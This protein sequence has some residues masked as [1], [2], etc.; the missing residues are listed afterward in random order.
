[1]ARNRLYVLLL[2]IPFLELFPQNYSFAPHAFGP[3]VAAGGIDQPRFQF[4]DIDGDGDQ[5]LF[6]LDKDELLWFYRNV[7]GQLRLEPK[8]DFSLT[9]G[10]WFRF[11]DIDHDGDKDCFTNGQFSE[12]AL[13]KNT[14]SPTVPRFQ[15]FSAALND[16]S[17]LELFS[18]RFS[19]PAFAD[20]DADGDDDLFSGGSIGSIAFYKN[21]GTP[22]IPQ[23]T[24]VTSAFNG[25]NIQGGG[26]SFPKVMHGASGIEFFD[27][28]SNGVLDLF[29]GDYFNP[30]LYYLQNTG[31]KQNAN[32]VLVDSTYPNEAVVQSY[33]FNVPQHVDV[34]GD[35]AVD[36]MIGSVFP[37]TEYD[38]MQFYKNTGTNA[39]P[40]YALQSKNF[41]PMI[42]AG[43]RSSVAAADFDGD[44]DADL[45]ITSAL[46]TVQIFDNTGTVSNPVFHVQPQSTFSLANNFYATVTAGDINNDGKIDLLIGNYDGRIR[47]FANT[48]SDGVISF[49]HILYPLDQ[50]DAGQNSAPCIVDIDHNGTNDVLVG[51]SGGHVV[52]L[53]NTGTNAAPVYTADPGFS[54]FDVGNDAIPF[55]AD[56]DKDGILDLLI[57]NNEGRMFQYKQ[58]SMS[59]STFD[60]VTEK[61]QNIDL[62]TQLS[63]CVFDMDHD[64]DNDLILGNGKGGIYYYERTA[65]ASRP[66]DNGALPSTVEV[67]QNY[68]NPFNPSTT[69]SFS[70]PQEARVTIEIIDVLGRPVETLTNGN[71]NAGKHS[72]VWNASHVAT[73]PYFYHVVVNI[74]DKRVLFSGKILYIK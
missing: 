54:P 7:N 34:D 43:S 12:V 44:G 5:D 35:G 67:Y 36:L 26:G 58:S 49:S 45:V 56:V 70:L 51:E 8:A 20:I 23:F 61:F 37:T 68:P 40:Y 2:C 42:D 32:L 21:I 25:I 24:F 19:I 63:P 17:G 64:G 38:N 66:A 72:I 69:I 30:S 3:N 60:L 74:K 1:M 57:G 16:T 27:A 29:W 52:L 73:G 71:M 41:I 48:S 50:Y 65:A 9:A 39:A 6:L 47:A 22:T 13:Y 11:V 55:A 46:G 59:A 18:E 31:T 33:G 15:L 62:R 53:K 4:T 14:G 28:D 10:S